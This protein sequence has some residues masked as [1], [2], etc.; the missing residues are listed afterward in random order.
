MLKKG[1]VVLMLLGILGMLALS[2]I[3]LRVNVMEGFTGK[4][5]E[6]EATLWVDG[7]NMKSPYND[8][9]MYDW[10]KIKVEFEKM[11]KIKIGQ[12][13]YGELA[14]FY[15]S[16]TA[17]N[18]TRSKQQRQTEGKTAAESLKKLMPYVTLTILDKTYG[19]TLNT[20]ARRTFVG[21]S[22]LM[23]TDNKGLTTLTYDRVAREILRMLSMTKLTYT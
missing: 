4:K 3:M 13:E 19:D 18:D 11:K 10:Q 8:F 16:L 21:F 22:G 2:V 9:V 1:R 7:S 14:E 6:L 20:G 23:K 15:G 17:E 5:S 12:K